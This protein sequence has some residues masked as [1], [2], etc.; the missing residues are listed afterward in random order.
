MKVKLEDV[1][2]FLALLGICGTIVILA[3]EFTP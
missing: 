2:E 1:Y 3:C